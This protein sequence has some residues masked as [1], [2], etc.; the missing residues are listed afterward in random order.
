MK[1]LEFELNLEIGGETKISKIEIL[2]IEMVSHV[3]WNFLVH[4]CR[5]YE[6]IQISDP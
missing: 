2:K 6:E 1:I 4:T 3:D 5:G